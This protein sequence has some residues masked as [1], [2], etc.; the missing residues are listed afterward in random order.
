VDGPW[1]LKSFTSTGEVT[2]VPNPTYSGSPKPSLAQFVEVPFTSDEAILNELKSGG[3]NALQV[4]ELPDDY[5]PQLNAIKAEGYNAVNFTSFSFSYFPL[6]L[7]NPTFGPVFRQLYFRQAFQHLVDANGWLEKIL[8]GYGVPTYGPVP[9]E[10]PNSFA[11]NFEKTNPYPF[12]VS[13][14]ASILKAHGWSDVGP[15]Q[16]ATCTKPGSGPGE[17]GAGV[18]DNL[19][20]KFSLQYQ[21]GVVVTQEEITDLKSQAAQVGIDLVVSA[22]PFAVVISNALNCGPDSG[23]SP[24]SAKCKWTAQDWGAGWVYAPDYAPTGEALFYTGSGADYSGYSSAYADYLINKTTTAPA[25]QTQK[26]MDT[27]QNYM[28][29]QLPVVYF[30]TATGQPTSAAIDLVSTHLGGFSNSAETNLTPE[31]WYLTK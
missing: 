28:A 18:A 27:Y 2:F 15:G 26:A 31:T 17:C 13:D 29:E 4:A 16:V 14:A 24:T 8:D 12:S 25:S 10:P 1:K 19:K 6:N 23:N 11:D 30:P 7:G 21:S 9:L 20:L 3:P 22:A 5:I